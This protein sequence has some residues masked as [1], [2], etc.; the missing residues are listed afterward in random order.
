M[1]KQKQNK[2][3]SR[4]LFATP[5]GMMA[6]T[7]LAVWLFWPTPDQKTAPNDKSDATKS[8]P[9]KPSIKS[10]PPPSVE[11]ESDKVTDDEDNRSVIERDAIETQDPDDIQTEADTT[12]ENEVVDKRRDDFVYAITPKG[13]TGAISAFRND[14]QNCYEQALK[15]EDLATGRIKFKFTIE[16]Q[17]DDA[18]NS[19]IAKI[20]EVGVQDATIDSEQLEDCVMNIIDELWFEPPQDG[21]V[22][23]NYPIFFNTD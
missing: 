4:R 8:S 11:T 16:A 6:I 12:E 23:V 1:N 9:R 20:T 10:A 22:M 5:I 7:V 18:E 17:P 15:D 2:E 3:S 19:D 21:P 14:M 13:I